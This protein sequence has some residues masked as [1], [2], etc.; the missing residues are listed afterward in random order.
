MSKINAY[1][2][3]L[4]ASAVTATA[5]AFGDL[6]LDEPLGADPLLFVVFV[7]LAVATE[8]RPLPYLF[9][10][11]GGSEITASWTF[12]MV[13]LVYA[14]LGPAL[15]ITFV[16]AAGADVVQRKPLN[17]V[18]FNGSQLTLCVAFAGFAIDWLATATHAED[19][20]LRWALA[21][22][23][24]GGIAILLNSLLLSGAIA[25]SSHVSLRDVARQTVGFNLTLDGLLIALAPIFVVVADHDPLFIALLLFTVWMIYVSTRLAMAHRH[26]S[27]HDLLTDLP[28]RRHFYE[29]AAMV[30]GGAGADARMAVV[31][32]DLNGF[33]AINDRLGHHVG[34]LVLCATAERLSGA[35]GDGVAARLGGDEFLLLLVDIEDIDDAVRRAAEISELL[36][37]P[38]DIEGVALDIGASV[39]VAV[40]PDHADDVAELVD[41][42]DV[43]MYQAK[44]TGGGVRLV[45]DRD[46][47]AG[48]GRMTLLA[49]LPAAIERS[50]LFV[51]FQPQVSLQDGRVTGAEALVRWIHPQ[52]GHVPPARFVSVAEGTQAI[53]LLTDFV[54]RTSLGHAAAWADAGHDL[55][56]AVNVSARNIQDPA[57]VKVMRL[58]IAEAG[59][60][61][62]RIEIEITEHMLMSDLPRAS[63][64]LQ[65]LREMGVTI[66]L[67]DFGTGYSSLTVL[68]NMPIDRI[69][70]D[71]T[72]VTNLARNVGDMYIVRAMVQLSHDLGLS[73]LAEGV[74]DEETL[75]LLA[76]LGCD[77][78]QGYG[79]ARPGPADGV[80]ELLTARAVSD[81]PQT[82]SS[83]T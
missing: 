53:D 52:L 49:E 40:Y 12:W 70:L 27:M 61:P 15:A 78:A 17:R 8:L 39:G 10:N 7:G 16:V 4:L 55:V 56:T 83:T 72:Y 41:F 29:H 9:V 80:V 65:Q 64:V 5:V 6:D 36:V 33:K 35:T 1:I 13:V 42:A 2:T 68:R 34:D 50:E 44:T 25:F 26:E 59:V 81:A 11:D 58:C 48:A 37:Q 22:M 21:I 54:L 46:A 18:L 31:Y 66:A 63:L 67:D 71:R 62:E 43:A 45:D 47:I 3:L 73:I 75:H 77:A 82:R 24:G 14:P 74:E 32:I 51:H 69:K 57:F 79:I 28:N 19:R 60:S 20:S 30:V 23:V 38:M 76:E